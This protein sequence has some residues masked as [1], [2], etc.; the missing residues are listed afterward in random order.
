MKARREALDKAEAALK[1]AEDAREDARAKNE[2]CEQAKDAA[3]AA[4]DALDRAEKAEK[5]A[6]DALAQA[7]P[8]PADETGAGFAPGQDDTDRPAAIVA[9]GDV[10]I[11]SGG[12]VAGDNG[13]RLTVDEI[14]STKDVT[15]DEITAGGDADIT[16]V[17][18]ITSTGKEPAIKADKIHIDA[19]STGDKPTKIGGEDGPL[20]VD[21]GEL[22][23]RGGD[24]DVDV[25]GDVTLD[26]VVADRFDLD[27]DGSVSQKDGTR[28][29]AKDLDINANGD[30]GS[31]DD[32][33]EIDSDRI[34][35][36]G[37]DIFIDNKSSELIVDE[38]IGNTVD[39]KTDGDINTSPDGVIKANDLTIS[40]S[41]TRPFAST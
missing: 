14:A 19:I 25:N 35:A 22:G 31:K 24:V 12:D 28:I 18:D 37:D 7:G 10:T 1:E 2:A 41:P 39:I 34:S 9:G 38:I 6:K 16:A 30:I 32:P 36:K 29:D 33:L 15:I 17:G 23:A 11:V 21:A 3:K 20:H 4:Q 40:E 27:A 13:G 8:L 5:D 26:D